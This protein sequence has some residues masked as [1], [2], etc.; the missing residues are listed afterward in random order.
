LSAPVV[1]PASDAIAPVPNETTRP[2]TVSPKAETH[3]VKTETAPAT[4]TLL[5][6]R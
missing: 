1:K 2:A 4:T 3:S 6:L 5:C